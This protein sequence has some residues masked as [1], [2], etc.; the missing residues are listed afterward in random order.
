MA[1]V[2]TEKYRPRRLSEIKGHTRIKTIFERAVK[3]GCIGFPP[4]ILYGPPGTGKTSIALALATADEHKIAAVVKRPGFA[5][6]GEVAEIYKEHGPAASVTKS[7]SR[8]AAF[9]KE[10]TE[11]QDWQEQSTHLVLTASAMRG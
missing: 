10:V 1:T 8:F 3:T 9:V 5:K 4:V 7:L 2:W 11:R 6:C